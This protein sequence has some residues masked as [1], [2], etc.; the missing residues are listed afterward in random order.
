MTLH[1]HH[2][3]GCTP[4]PLAHYLK[5]I[6]ILRLVAQQKDPDVRGFW[7]DQHFCLLTSLDE[8]ALEAFFLDEYSPTPFVSP[9]NKGS[10]FYAKSDKGLT[11]L[12]HSTAERFKPFRFGIAEARAP[13]AGIT[14]ADAEVRR[15][16]PPPR[17]LETV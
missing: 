13:L 6:G 11:P 7:C 2:L 4:T 10:G 8:G 9:W 3:T 5:A 12:E 16:I 17:E 1:L 15:S 14:A